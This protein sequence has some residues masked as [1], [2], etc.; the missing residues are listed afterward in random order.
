MKNFALGLALAATA[1]CL[2]QANGAASAATVLAAPAARATT[3]AESNAANSAGDIPDT[4]AFVRYAGP[5]YSVLVPEG[6]SRTQRGS[7][8]TFSSNSN[9]EMIEVRPASAM[10][11]LRVRFHAAGSITLKKGATLGGVPAAHWFFRSQSAAN[12]VTGKRVELENELYS[13]TRNGRAV[14]LLLSAPAGAD[15]GDQWKKIAG[16]FRWK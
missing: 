13:A 10:L 2:Q 7:A 16:S 15:N 12:A 6:W 11:D 5:G 1:A 3:P 8:V 4:Q 9:S 14:A